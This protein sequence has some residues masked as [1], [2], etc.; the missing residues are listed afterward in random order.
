[1]E[2]PQ[3]QM[4]QGQPGQAPEQMQQG[5]P[6]QGGQDQQMQQVMQFVEQAL[7]QG[8][9]P[10]DVAAQLLQSQVPPELIM[11]AFVQ[12]GMP[13]EEAQRNIEQAMQGGGQ[14]PQGP[15]EEGMEGA[16]SNPQEEGAEQAMPMPEDGAPMPE[17]GSQPQMLFGGLF[18]NNRRIKNKKNTIVNNYYGYNPNGGGGNGGGNNYGYPQSGQNNAYTNT[19]QGQS[20]F[21]SLNSNEPPVPYDPSAEMD[22]YENRVKEEQAALRNGVPNH[23]GNFVKNWGDPYSTVNDG[24]PRFSDGNFGPNGYTPAPG[25]RNGGALSYYADGGSVMDEVNMM[26]K[27]QVDPR[28]IIKSV[29][30]AVSQGKITPEEATSIMEQVSSMQSAQDPQGSDV[31]MADQ[32][33]DPQNY[34]P[35][36][37]VPD[38]SMG[39]AMFG[40]KLKRNLIKAYGGPATAPAMDSENY[41]KDRSTMFV[42]SVKGDMYKATLD[43]AF[44]SLTGKSMTYGGLVKA[45]NGI[46]LKDGQITID[47]TQYASDAEYKAA[48]WN[49]NND[50]ANAKTQITAEHLK[51]KTWTAPPPVAKFQFMEGDRF[52]QDPGGAYIIRK[53]GTRETIPADVAANL[54][55]ANQQNPYG[56]G[57]NQYG[58]NPY[59]VSPVGYGNPYQ[60]SP[61]DQLY[62]SA[63]PFARL[64]AGNRYGDP[65]LTGAN[66]PGGMN[67]AQFLGNAGGFDGLTTG[68][69]GK[70][71][72][73]TWRVGEAEKFKEGSIWKGNRRKGVRYQIDWGNAAAMNPATAQTAPSVAAATTPAAP[74]LNPDGTQKITLPAGYMPDVDPMTQVNPNITSAVNIPGQVPGLPGAQT[75]WYD[76]IV[77]PANVPTVGQPF[78]PTPV[79]PEEVVNPNIS[80][81]GAL[82]SDKSRSDW[83]NI[84]KQDDYKENFTQKGNDFYDKN[85]EAAD[86]E[87]PYIPLDRDR[88]NYSSDKEYYKAMYPD[89]SNREIR[90]MDRRFDDGTDPYSKDTK[91]YTA[92]EL[93]ANDQV[94]KKQAKADKEAAEIQA[95]KDKKAARDAERITNEKADDFEKQSKA[96]DAFKSPAMRAYGGGV[97]P[98]ALQNAIHLIN[99]AFGGMIPQALDGNMGAAGQKGTVE[100][101]EGSKFNINW[102]NADPYLMKK[103]DQLTNFA[104]QFNAYN[105]EKEIASVSSIN[106]PR[107][108]Y[109]VMPRGIYGQQGDMLSN[110]IGNNVLNPTD[111]GRNN[112]RTVY[113][114]GGRLYEV[115]GD[116]ELDDSEL[117]ALS[118]A[119]IK[120]RRV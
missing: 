11:E 64:L 53:D 118:A 48:L 13:Q 91:T 32:S 15:G 44:P 8:A 29:Q 104:T 21:P 56:Y 38:Q 98:E 51:D 57:A 34:D 36:M 108:E 73:Q 120:F 59:A 40:G 14:Q 78:V 41:A 10:A 12:M 75:N 49:W 16:M 46:N 37:A 39:M 52:G 35:A 17:D 79:T 60:Q 94:A 82:L 24:F 23:G 18:S 77:G 71:G 26:I 90:R 6:Q 9:Q 81:E 50:P 27:N 93:E 3:A 114:F 25:Y 54:A 119:G 117:E 103:A 70:V 67:A 28:D 109:S 2:N 20:E 107:E 111:V 58:A 61:Y 31:A 69:T 68:M 65:R 62:S 105:P 63:S 7:Q 4:P 5:Q 115:G 83:R 89:L 86:K 80:P 33:Q 106:I 19:T 1:M 55:G 84:R 116:V 30:A 76:P 97:D 45:G 66:L 110:N 74:A 95:D 102:K 113:A 92:K 22:D 47:P 87:N 96:K 42:N 101:S 99:R 85:P 88:K 112:Q 100:A 72:D 43:S